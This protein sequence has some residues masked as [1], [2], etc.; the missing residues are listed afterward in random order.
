MSALH[1]PLPADIATLSSLPPRA[2]TELENA[3]RAHFADAGFA[4]QT[5]VLGYLHYLENL[6]AGLHEPQILA[7]LSL[8]ALQQGAAV[9]LLWRAWLDQE[10][11]DRLPPCGDRIAIACIAL[12]QGLLAQKIARHRSLDVMLPGAGDFPGRL[13][14]AREH[15]QPGRSIALIQVELP[16]HLP[17]VPEQLLPEIALR[18]G[19]VLRDHDALF[20]IDRHTI[21]LLFANLSGSGHAMLAANRINQLFEDPVEN[22]GLSLRLHPRIGI[23]LYPDHAETADDLLAAAAIATHRFASD[24]IGLYEPERDRIGQL[25]QKLEVPLREA[26]RENRFHLALQPQIAR[27]G[28]YLHG[29]EALLRWQDETLGNIPPSEIVMV[30]EQ[31]GL[32]SSLTRWVIQASLR[33]FRTLLALNIPGNISINLA[34]ESLYDR[35]LPDVIASALSVWHVPGERVVFEITE[36]AL[37]EN[38]E[39]AAQS[40]HKLKALGCKLAL[41]DFG[42]GYSSLNYLK[43]LPIDE[44]K[45]DASFI[46]GLK[47]SEKDAHIVTAVIELAHKLGITVISEGV[48]DEETARLLDAAGNDVIQGYFYSRPL[49]PAQLP[50]FVQKLAQRFPA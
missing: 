26:L 28:R 2:L 1:A 3:L 25:L 17:L 13:D 32:M 30:A 12:L 22:S 16:Q 43:A 31:M 37:I 10:Y 18:I 7:Q 27:H 39:T 38:I 34:A 44:L 36:S 40:L 45:I 8:P 50:D 6:M 15:S 46:R 41:D 47:A 49:P 11:G 19:P 24:E 20:L 5:E 42:T 4:S 35:E 21:G 48:E 29:M 33:E 14:Y 9:L 23:A